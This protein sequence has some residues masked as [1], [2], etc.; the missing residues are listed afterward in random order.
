MKTIKSH[1]LRIYDTSTNKPY[2]VNVSLCLFQNSYNLNK[3][4]GNYILIYKMKFFKYY[5][6]YSRSISTIIERTDLVKFFK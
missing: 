2:N 3:Y 6:N 4:V 5:D 1:F